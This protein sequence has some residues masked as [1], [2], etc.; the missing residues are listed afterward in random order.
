VTDFVFIHHGSVTTLRP[1]TDEAR[2]WLAENV[3]TSE[4]QWFGRALV[5]EP[6]MAPEIIDAI[7]RDGLTLGGHGGV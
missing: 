4:A 5:I 1:E 6:R 2:E 3:D 7:D